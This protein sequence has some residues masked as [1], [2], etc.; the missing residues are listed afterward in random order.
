MSARENARIV[1]AHYELF[2]SRD[3]DRSVVLIDRAVEWTI[4]STGRVYRGIRGYRKC[5]NGWVRGCSDFTF[6][7]RNLIA[8]EGWVVVES[9]GVG[10]HDGP[11]DLVD[12]LIPPSGRLIRV[13]ICEI[14]SADGKKILGARLYSDR[15]NLSRALGQE[16]TGL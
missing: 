14:M 3:F 12:S 7:I 1:R 11:F 9:E 16:Q 8:T 2:N 6:E 4:V 13:A 10:I 15:T 5:L